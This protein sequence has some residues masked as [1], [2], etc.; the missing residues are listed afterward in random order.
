MSYGELSYR[1][2]Y[3][4]DNEHVNVLCFTPKHLAL[5]PDGKYRIDDLPD[6]LRSK[7]AV[8][9]I[10]EAPPPPVDVA[11]VGQRVGERAFW[12]YI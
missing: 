1:V 2:E 12:V 6:V 3:L 8:L 11:G 5:I 4:P 9:A 7:L 10:M